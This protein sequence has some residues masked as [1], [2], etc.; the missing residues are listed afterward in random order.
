MKG[1]VGAVVTALVA[2]AYLWPSFVAIA[3]RQRRPGLIFAL[4]LFLGW[5]IIG[6][7]VAYRLASKSDF[8]DDRRPRRRRRRR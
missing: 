1:W 7:I 6:W 8:E 2:I 5:T 4:N 3:Q